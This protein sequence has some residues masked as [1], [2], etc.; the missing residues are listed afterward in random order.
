M[1]FHIRY[2][3][4]LDLLNLMSI[5]TGESLYVNAHPE[6]FERFGAPLSDHLKT[7]LQKAVETNGNAMLGPAL[8]HG[9]SVYPRFE[10]LNVVRLGQVLTPLLGKDRHS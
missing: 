6:A 9:L 2:A 8:C 1:R 3:Y 5:L 7:C 10:S 4:S